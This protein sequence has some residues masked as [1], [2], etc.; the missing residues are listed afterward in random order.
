MASRLTLRD[1]F[2]FVSLCLLFSTLLS[3]PLALQQQDKVKVCDFC[4]NPTH[5]RAVL[6]NNIDQ[7]DSVVTLSKKQ[8][9]KLEVAAKRVFKLANAIEEM[10]A[11]NPQQFRDLK[12]YRGN[13]LNSEFFLS[14]IRKTLDESQRKQWEAFTARLLSFKHYK[15]RR[16]L[17]A[18]QTIKEKSEVMAGNMQYYL[19]MSDDQ[20]E[21]VAELL[22][23]YLTENVEFDP[24]LVQFTN[25]YES[26]LSEF[27]TETQLLFFDGESLING[28]GTGGANVF[29]GIWQKFHCTRCHSD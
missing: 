19:N 20:T 13:P 24:T 9:A 4:P 14:T 25:Q 10:E 26:E 21:S 22:V 5:I 1:P 11:D 27:M 8:R 28:A 23:R 15:G 29:H 17:R 16:D 3:A 7:I 18:I 2:P 12:F 6:Q